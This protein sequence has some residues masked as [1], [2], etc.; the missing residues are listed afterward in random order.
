MSGTD[1]GRLLL[2]HRVTEG[3]C[4]ATP[5]RCARVARAPLGSE[6]G[7]RGGMGLEVRTPCEPLIS[8]ALFRDGSLYYGLCHEE[9]EVGPSTTLYTIRNAISWAGTTELAGCTPLGTAPVDDGVAVLARCGDERV[10]TVLD[11]MG[12]E[13]A[14][15]RPVERVTGCEDGR[16][17]LRIRRGERESKLT[18]GASMDHI[19]ALLRRTS[20]RR[21]RARSGPAR[22]SSSASRRAAISRCAATSVSPAGGSSASIGPTSARAE[23]EPSTPTATERPPCALCPGARGRR[24]PRRPGRLGRASRGRRRSRRPCRGA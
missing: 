20:R 10:A 17:V 13:T 9:P 24:S 18:L 12:A 3:E 1:E 15:Y 4:V 23:P 14:T 2:Q 7:E 5:G 11:Q 21:A 6:A 22:R 8:G 19:E 16:P